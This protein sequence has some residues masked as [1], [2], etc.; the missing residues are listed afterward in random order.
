[1]TKTAIN[2]I[3]A[4]ITDCLKIRKTR[5]I[6]RAQTM[7]REGFL[8]IQS[9]HVIL[10]GDMDFIRNRLKDYPMFVDYY[11]DNER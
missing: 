6:R 1:M 5:G 9:D 3:N 2:E 7:W 8:S 10:K 11:T 4:L